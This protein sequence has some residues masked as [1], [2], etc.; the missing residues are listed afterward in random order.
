VGIDGSRL[1]RVIDH[2]IDKFV[3]LIL[4]TRKGYNQYAFLYNAPGDDSVPCKEDRIVILKIDGTG[5]FVAVGMLNESQGAKPGEKIFYGRDADGKIVSTLKMLN[6]GSIETSAEGE[7]GNHKLKVKGD[8]SA[9]VEG[10][11]SL[12]TKGDLSAETE[13]AGSLKVKGDLTLEVDGAINEKGKGDITKEATGKYK[14]KG[15][16]IEI[17]GLQ[18]LILKTIGSAVWCPN[19]VTNCFICGAPH[20]GPAMG[21]IGLK[22]S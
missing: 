12:K 6:D 9:D 18:D 19:G 5:K 15:A 13:G 4:E 1:G 17:E 11:G 20:G 10:I 2:A 7:T 14:I 3:Q 8:L 22:G 21:I 16:N